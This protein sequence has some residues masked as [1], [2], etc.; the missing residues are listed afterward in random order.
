MESHS[1][2]TPILLNLDTSSRYGTL[3]VLAVPLHAPTFSSWSM[4]NIILRVWLAIDKWPPFL[5]C[6]WNAILGA[7]FAYM[8]ARYQSSNVMQYSGIWY[9]SIIHGCL[10]IKDY[11]H[12]KAW[13][14][15]IIIITYDSYAKEIPACIDTNFIW[16]LVHSHEIM[17]FFLH[18][19]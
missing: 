15:I 8:V 11:A 16:K 19:H 17:Y 2:N 4:R 13:L 10:L 3:L 5:Y 14:C 9:F 12:T 7:V 6:S 18:W 1:E